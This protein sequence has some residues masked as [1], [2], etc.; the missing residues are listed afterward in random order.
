MFTAPEKL[1]FKTG[2]TYLIGDIVT[3]EMWS[4]IYLKKKVMIKKITVLPL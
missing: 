1:V 4:A 2:L 3:C